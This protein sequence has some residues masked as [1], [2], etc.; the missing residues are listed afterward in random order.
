MGLSRSLLP[1]VPMGARPTADHSSVWTPRDVIF[2]HA[3]SPRAEPLTP[4]QSLLIL[5]FLTTSRHPGIRAAHRE[6]ER[7]RDRPPRWTQQ[8]DAC[9]GSEAECWG[10]AGCL[11]NALLFKKDSLLNTQ[12]VI[13]LPIP[14]TSV[15]CVQALH[16]VLSVH[17]NVH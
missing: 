8:K 6:W 5:T 17:R 7:G 2:L 11:S 9:P 14:L 4:P 16:W 1:A 12:Y 10:A 13:S 3:L 15:H